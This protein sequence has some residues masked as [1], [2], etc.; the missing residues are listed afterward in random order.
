MTSNRKKPG[1]A[2]WPTVAT[3]VLIVPLI[4]CG[5]AWWIVGPV[6]PAHTLE[7]IHE[8]TRDDVR[9]ILGEPTEIQSH[10]DWI[11]VRP[12]TAG[13]V[14]ISFGENGRVQLINDEQAC[15]GLFDNGSSWSR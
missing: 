12:P 10:R 1:V 2:F 5:A 6:I 14:K 3:V 11:Y 7:S 8:A 13:W 9:R 15:P 4:V